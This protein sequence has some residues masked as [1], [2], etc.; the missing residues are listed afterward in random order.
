MHESFARRARS[1]PESLLFP[2]AFAIG[3]AACSPHLVVNVEA[4]ASAPPET[5]AL[6]KIVEIRELRHFEAAPKDPSTPSLA[7]AE[8]LDDPAIVARAIGRRRD[9]Y[10]AAA[11]DVLLPEGRT[12]IDLMRAVTTKALESDGY[13]VVDQ[14][15]PQYAQAAPLAV[16]IEQFWEWN[17]PSGLGVQMEFKGIVTMRSAELIGTEPAIASGYARAYGA[18][19]LT[20]NDRLDLFQRGMNDLAQNMSAKIKAPAAAKT[21][22]N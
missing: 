3:L 10:G 11:G 6:A 22:A 9:A 2:A 21:S 16:D 7:Q 15:S 4:P 12:V 19:L 18:V 17:G 1:S 14:S 5:V 8:M 20:N 13:R